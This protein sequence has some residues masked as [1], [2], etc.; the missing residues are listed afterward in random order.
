MQVAIHCSEDDLLWAGLACTEAD[1]CPAYLEISAVDGS[2]DWIVA[3]GN[4]HSESVTLFTLLLVSDDGGSTWREANERIRG[5]GLDG[6]QLGEG[7]AAWVSGAELFPLTQNPFLLIT[8]DGGQ[9]WRRA[10]LSADSGGGSIQEFHFEGPAHGLLV[11]DKGPG[12]GAARYERYET[13]DGGL[14]WE[15][16][17]SS[18]R[19]IGLAS[20]AQQPSWRVR[21]DAPSRAFQIER[22]TGAQWTSVAS[23]AF[24]A[25]ACQP[26]PGGPAHP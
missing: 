12:E 4:L 5:A 18:D 23:F 10:P 16:K 19:P 7:G 1:P 13:Q 2:G 25:G 26:E 22:R 17:E 11:L 15:L 21:A 8:G 24:S 9:N 20:A 14:S 3:A 6:V